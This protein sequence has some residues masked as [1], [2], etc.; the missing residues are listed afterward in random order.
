MGLTSDF[1]N[2]LEPSQTTETA[3]GAF[4]DG[5]LVDLI[6]PEPG[7]ELQ[8]VRC[9]ES[10]VHEN[11][12]LSISGTNYVPIKVESSWLKATKFPQ[13]VGKKRPAGE[14]FANV[15]SFLKAGMNL[16]PETLQKLAAFAISTWFTDA[17]HAAPSLWVVAPDANDRRNVLRLLSY[18]CRRAVLLADCKLSTLACIRAELKPTLLFE[19]A[20]R[21]LS[22]QILA[23]TTRRGFYVPRNGRALDCSFAVAVLPRSG[24]QGRTAATTRFTAQQ[25]HFRL[26]DKVL[27][28][29]SEKLQADL[30]RYRLRPFPEK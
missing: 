7:T 26:D 29:E 12:E 15:C 2:S 22:A 3:G 20:G 24:R 23:I 27:E 4:S 11:R 6:L 28:Q 25:L 13:K 19:S 8:L 1:V 5:N 30:L 10:R 9:F 14:L 18:V 21:A 17:F 16:E